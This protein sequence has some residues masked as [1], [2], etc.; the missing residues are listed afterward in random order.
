MRKKDLI[1][2]L[3]AKQ[4]YERIVEL[5]TENHS[6]TLKY[7]QMQ[8]FHPL[9]SPMRWYAIETLGV[10]TR[11]LAPSR[12]APYKNLLGRF[13][14]AMNEEGGNVPW[15][16]PEAMA[17]IISEMPD[18]FS[19]Y[20]PLFITNGLENPICHRGVLWGVGQVGTVAPAQVAPFYQ[21]LL[22]FLESS[23]PDLAGYAAWAFGKT[24]CQDAL[25][26]LVKLQNRSEVIYLFQDGNLKEHTIG[27]IASQ[28]LLGLSQTSSTS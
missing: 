22:P 6:Q 28:A 15:S 24:K 13:W 11:H 26:E 9:D 12:I 17:S 18:T 14:W 16:S 23:D 19:D 7:V 1:K 8:L 20:T 21:D 5:A 3:I 2:N 4:D 10:L 27:E 25:S